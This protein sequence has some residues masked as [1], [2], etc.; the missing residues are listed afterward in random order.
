MEDNAN[1][2]VHKLSWGK[3]IGNGIAWTLGVVAVVAELTVFYFLGA[4]TTKPIVDANGIPLNRWELRDE[5]KMKQVAQ[6]K[7]DKQN[8]ENIKKAF[9]ILSDRKQAKIV[10]TQTALKAHNDSIKAKMAMKKM[11]PTHVVAKPQF[12]KKTVTVRMKN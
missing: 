7:K 4:P 9:Q 10:S 11:K 12:Q 1:T 2:H 6:E 3:R 8:Q 5:A